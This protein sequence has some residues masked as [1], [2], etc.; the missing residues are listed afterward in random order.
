MFTVFFIEFEL[1]HTKQ[2]QNNSIT[3][4]IDSDATLTNIDYV[5]KQIS[6]GVV[7]QQ[8]EK[9]KAG[10]LVKFLFRLCLAKK[11]RKLSF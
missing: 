9:R 5:L 4:L 11:L 2:N 8:T 6:F 1:P 10:G 3:I 7:N